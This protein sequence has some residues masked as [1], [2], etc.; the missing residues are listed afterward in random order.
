MSD[1][2][3][4]VTDFD[5]VAY[6]DGKLDPARAETVRRYIEENPDAAGRVRAFQKQNAE[7]QARFDPVLEEPLPDHLAAL[8][9]NSGAEGTG[10]KA[11]KAA[12]VAVLAVFT[13]ASGWV[14]GRATQAS[15]FAAASFASDATAA[16][17]RANTELPNGAEGTSAPLRWLTK[18]VSLE[19]KTPDLR[20]RNYQL[21]AH[22]KVRLNGQP[23]VQLVYENPTRGRLSVFLRK[24]WRSSPP[25]VHL[26][27][28]GPR[29]LAY[30]LD[31]PIAYGVV[32][33]LDRRDLQALA[34]DIEG[35]IAI[36]PNVRGGKVEATGSDVAPKTDVQ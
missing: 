10:R 7:L 8:T 21:V 30:W 24:R 27:T 36:E 16:H 34:R 6:A 35:K 25:Q 22:E 2:N 32:G 19:L 29:P 13:G 14:L 3:D 1:T 18:R 5:L 31:G 15:D 9:R 28:D 11:L 23:G 4:P 33:D 17:E 20:A 26:T 12:A